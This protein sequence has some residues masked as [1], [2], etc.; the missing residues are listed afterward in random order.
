MDHTVSLV[1]MPRK[2]ACWYEIPLPPKKSN[3]LQMEDFRWLEFACD[4]LPAVR[5]SIPSEITLFV[6]SGSAAF[7][8][9][10]AT[11]LPETL[12]AALNKHHIVTHGLQ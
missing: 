9:P 6:Y 3:F 4:L 11:L 2:E 7:F 5:W 1:V 10:H 8:L 12:V